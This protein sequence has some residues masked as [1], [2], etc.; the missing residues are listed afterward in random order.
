MPGV[1]LT[2]EQF[3]II[4]QVTK[5]VHG[6]P[7]ERWATAG[8]PPQQPAEILGLARDIRKSLPV[9][10]VEIPPQVARRWQALIH[11]TVDA[12]GADELRFRTGYTEEEVGAAAAALGGL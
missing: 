5:E 10:G 9:G 12:L 2:A 6:V 1:P 11:V 7:E 4:F 8:I 3:R